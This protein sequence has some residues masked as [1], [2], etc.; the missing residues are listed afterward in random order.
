[1]GVIGFSTV[2]FKGHGRQ[3]TREI[4][5]SQVLPTSPKPAVGVMVT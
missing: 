5:V 4:T 1:M 2:V 3:E